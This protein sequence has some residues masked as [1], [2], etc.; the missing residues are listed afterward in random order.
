MPYYSR[1]PKRDPNFDNY[2][3]RSSLDTPYLPL[4]P[5][6]RKTLEGGPRGHQRFFGLPH[7]RRALSLLRLGCRPSWRR[8]SRSRRFRVHEVHS[9]FFRVFASFAAV[10]VFVLG[11]DD[12]PFVLCC[13]VATASASTTRAQ[14][15]KSRNPKPQTPKP[16][17]PKPPTLV[18]VYDVVGH[19]TRKARSDPL[20]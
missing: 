10:G 17:T 14:H 5:E 11:V 18:S 7:L 9:S 3:H 1:D 2:P 6:S 20:A 12:K 19:A 16:Q 8:R 4:Q 15:G 13:T